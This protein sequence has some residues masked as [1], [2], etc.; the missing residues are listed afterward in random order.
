LLRSFEDLNDGTLFADLTTVEHEDSIRD[1]SDNSQVV[2]NQKQG[3][4]ELEAEF[5]QEREDGSLD[6]DIKR[7]RDLVANDQLWLRD[8]SSRDSYALAFSTRKLARV[9]MCDVTGKLNLGKEIAGGRRG[10]LS[11]KPE[12]HPSRAD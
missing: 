8:Q 4:T 1:A 9:A 12:E 2:G 10:V 5:L 11:G 7:R 6:R 3:K